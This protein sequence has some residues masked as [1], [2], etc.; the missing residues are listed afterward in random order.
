MEA[1]NAVWIL[2][3]LMFLGFF[4]WGYP[5]ITA[6][7]RYV[8]N[9]AAWR[10]KG[11]LPTLVVGNLGVG[12]TGKTP[13]VLFLLEAFSGERLGVLSRGYGRNTRGY[14]RVELD[15]QAKEV[16]DEP[17]E[18]ASVFPNLPVGVCEDRLEGLRRLQSETEIDWVVLDDGYQHIK[19]LPTKSVI[20]TSFQRPFWNEIFG[21][22]LGNLREFGFALKEADALV[23][24]KCPEH[25]DAS[26]TDDLA[27]KLN[28]PSHRIF[29][30]RYASSPGECVHGD[31]SKLPEKAILVTGV[32]NA[33]LVKDSIEHC[34]IVEHLEYRDHHAFTPRDVQSWLKK[35][36]EKG[37]D[38]LIVT[39]K[40]WQ[41]IRRRELLQ[42]LHEAQIQIWEIHTN[43]EILWN[44]K[45]ELLK[46]IYPLDGIV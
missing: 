14:V 42:V 37:V 46:T 26:F 35:C 43:V 9:L 6:M 1:T 5:C 24:T 12:G 20:L 25:L 13:M 31:S 44:K 39:R 30:S 21:V 22:P 23:V 11:V 38:S 10:Q 28:Y 7:K 4:S 3:I 41:R 33:G 18:I 19:L 2:A 29:A 34:I 45:E 27:A 40:D 15:S 36:R 17:L 8:Y 32:V 16:G